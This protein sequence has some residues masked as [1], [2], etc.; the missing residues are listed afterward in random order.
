MLCEIFEVEPSSL[1]YTSGGGEL[2]TYVLCLLLFVILQQMTPTACAPIVLDAASFLQPILLVHLSTA[3]LLLLSTVFYILSSLLS[4]KVVF[5]VLLCYI[6]G[7]CEEANVSVTK[8]AHVRLAPTFSVNKWFSTFGLHIVPYRLLRF[9]RRSAF[10]LFTCC[11]RSYLS[12]I[13][14]FHSCITKCFLCLI[15]CICLLNVFYTY[16]LHYH[17][18]ISLI[19]CFNV[20]IGFK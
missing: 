17:M 15:F 2:P 13:T 12:F 7:T 4:C 6:C 19:A 16:R 18:A 9:V 5:C 1:Y 10:V 14:V 20:K 8:V 11:C 3:H